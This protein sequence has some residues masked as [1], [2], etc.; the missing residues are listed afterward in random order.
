MS[1]SNS[2]FS[3]GSDSSKGTSISDGSHLLERTEIQ[4]FVLH[5]QLLLHKAILMYSR[6]FKSVLTTIFCPLMWVLF[7]TYF[8]NLENVLRG[9]EI[10]EGETRAMEDIEKCWG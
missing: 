7:I 2:D 6:N 1:D 10:K 5:I 9:L 3:T 8:N 4:K